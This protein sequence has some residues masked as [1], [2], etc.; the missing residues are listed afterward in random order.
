MSDA[1]DAART[2]AA[3]I[4][5]RFGWHRSLV[6]RPR[7]SVGALALGSVSH[8]R[9]VGRP[10]SLR[11]AVGAPSFVG[12]GVGRPPVGPRGHPFLRLW[13]LSHAEFAAPEA[14]A[15]QA[16]ISAHAGRLPR[17]TSPQQTPFAPG[18]GLAR[19]QREV[20]PV[21]LV[22][23]VAA[24]GPVVSDR[25]RRRS[26]SVPRPPGSRGRYRVPGVVAREAV[27][28]ERPEV[29]ARAARALPGTSEEHAVG[30]PS[31]VPR[32]PSSD[33]PPRG[34]AQGR[35]DRRHAGEP[36]TSSESGSSEATTH[37]ASAQSDGPR[38]QLRPREGR[39]GAASGE[40]D[41]PGGR[42]PSGGM[43]GEWGAGLLS[44]P[45][46]RGA[47]W[48]A[49]AMLVSH[50]GDQ[51]TYV[52]LARR[53]SER[54]GERGPFW[55]YT[56]QFPR[57][58]FRRRQREREAP[59][60]RPQRRLRARTQWRRLME[61]GGEIVDSP[62][63]SESGAGWSGEGGAGERFGVAAGD[64]AVSGGAGAHR[65]RNT[66]RLPGAG[67]EAGS[68]GAIRVRAWALPRRALRRDPA[69][70]EH[71]REPWAG[72]LRQASGQG[73]W[74]PAIAWPPEGGGKVADGELG[75]RGS[76]PAAAPPFGDRIGLA[77]GLGTLDGLRAAHGLAEMGGMRRA[78]G[79]VSLEGGR[80]P[81]LAPM[82]S[83]AARRGRWRLAL[84]ERYG[85]VPEGYRY[86]SGRA[87]VLGQ[88]PH[89]EGAAGQR[90]PGGRERDP[91]EAVHALPTSL[92]PLASALGVH[93]PVEV[94]S[95]PSTRQSL[96]AM[97]TVAATVGRRILV[98]DPVDRSPHALGVLAHELVHV[99]AGDASRGP[100]LFDDP[101]LD[102]EE[103]RARRVGSLVRALVGDDRGSAGA[104]LGTLTAM[105]PPPR[106]V[107]RRD[108]EVQG[109]G[110]TQPTGFPPPAG[111][112]P[113][114]GVSSRSE[115]HD[116]VLAEL[117]VLYAR[118]VVSPTVGD[119]VAG[120]KATVA[121]A[122]SLAPRLP[123]PMGGAQVG[124]GHGVE[125]GGGRV[126]DDMGA[127]RQSSAPRA[128]E[129]LDWLVE[130]VER[131]LIR[132]LDAQGLRHRPDVL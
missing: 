122:M 99:A 54:V 35:S 30:E 74:W 19:L 66:E 72:R 4:E 114:S 92:E 12:V 95:G 57:T 79:G 39:V 9:V 77:R 115:E 69:G 107:R 125:S 28:K 67:S 71:A 132:E 27:S 17:A 85:V 16:A 3:G 131:R 81:W 42:E 15:L 113:P 93:G 129:F 24:V 90:L 10:L 123:V 88:P 94:Q 104:E 46:S 89:R 14:P 75:A 43:S 26:R 22:P 51:E 96:R 91:G 48:G 41:A 60:G 49:V 118:S 38:G 13:R 73:R 121:G 21:R 44:D 7:P 68:R 58:T 120:D 106:G 127:I 111:V 109:A 103:R 108:Q 63:G 56:P 124:F 52:G 64:V 100:R 61:G 25:E 97:G 8:A 87:R 37:Q 130:Q 116:G 112:S 53:G 6:R 5:R 119:P 45:W 33:A 1:G 40:G 55:Q 18:S 101:H 76:E 82:S 78:L 126:V 80:M 36:A 31:A 20:L 128:E 65:L 23:D 62:K 34:G 70:A 11:S 86:A 83:D 32:A 29:D 59:P 102:D 98:A 110:T 105:P 50:I 2:F 47:S 84:P 117:Q